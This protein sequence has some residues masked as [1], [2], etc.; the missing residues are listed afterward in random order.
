[1]PL[2]SK[3]IKLLL[4][5]E[6]KEPPF[7]FTAGMEDRQPGVE[8]REGGAAAE[9]VPPGKQR[10]GDP[11]IP[12]ETGGDHTRPGHSSPGRRARKKSSFPGE[13]ENTTGRLKGNSSGEDQAGDDFERQLHKTR[14]IESILLNKDKLFSELDKNNNTLERIFRIPLNKDAVIR[15]FFIGVDPPVRALLIFYDGL[16][17][18]L[19]Q[20]QSILQPLM[21][22]AQ[23]RPDLQKGAGPGGR[24]VLS[25]KALFETVRETLLP[26]NQ[27]NI[28]ATFTEVVSNVLNGNSAIVIDSVDQALFVESKGWEHRGVERPQVEA[29]I[30]G[31]QE[32]FTELIKVNT[33]LIR[34]TLRKPSL[35]TE[36]LKVG[37]MDPVQ[38]AIMYMDDICNPGLAREVKRRL[39]SIKADYVYESGI[40]EQFIEDSPYHLAP[41]VLAT[42]R[43]DRVA[44][45][46]NEGKVAIFTESNPYALVVPATFFSLMQAAEDAYLRWP[47]ASFT[48]IIR[49]M[50]LALALLL[51]GFYV[52]VTSYHPEFIPT[53]LLLVMTGN[54]EKVPF[55]TIIEVLLMEVSFELIREAGIRIPGTVGTTLGIVGALILGQAAVAANIVSPI[56]IVVVAVTALGSFAIPNY[57]LSYYVRMLR[58]AYILMAAFMGLLGMIVGIFIHLGLMSNMRSFGVPFMAPVG[59]VTTSGPDYFLRGPVW[60]QE[61]RPDYLDPLRR[62]RQPALSRGWIKPGRKKGGG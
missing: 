6:P 5:Q 30:R 22:L 13:V 2:F 3:L 7:E 18:K 40:L 34:K 62:R 23:L 8:K 36:Y 42:E 57:S 12:R 25:G 39:E 47:F 29:V 17:D 27:V 15:P 26:G 45:S 37:G 49:Y 44:S 20:N 10:Q 41:Q 50:G 53:D 11:L 38:C 19:T 31:P 4:Y 1:M 43:P 56:L 55:P 21:L 9:I 35:V 58:F 60:E 16:T 59:P 52:A 61:I 46:I 54:R 28:G 32:A 14:E 24:P 51:P 48:R 33:T